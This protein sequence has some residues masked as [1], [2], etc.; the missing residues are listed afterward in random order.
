MMMSSTMGPI[1]VQDYNRRPVPTLHVVQSRAS[2]GDE[3][4]A[5][6]VRAFRLVCPPVDDDRAT[7]EREGAC[8]NYSAPSLRLA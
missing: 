2:G 1:A 3:R 4:A 7:R 8:R 5:R 6:R